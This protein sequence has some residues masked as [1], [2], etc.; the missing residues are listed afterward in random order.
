MTDQDEAG[1]VSPAENDTLH[2]EG[3]NLSPEDAIA[4]LAQTEGESSEGL[5]GYEDADQTPEENAPEEIAGL[6]LENLTEDGWQ[7]IADHLNSRGADRIAG[8]IKERSKLQAKLEDRSEQKEDPFERPS[9]PTKNPYH[10]VEPIDELQAKAADVDEMIEWAEDLLEDNEDETGDAIIHEENE[11]A[12]S[13]SE[14]RSLLR[15]ARKARKTHLVNRF[16][17]LQGKEQVS[18]QR[19]Q[20]RQ[21]AE[22]EFAWM[23]EED[24]PIRQRYEGV[25]SHPGLAALKDDF[26]EIPLVL[27][28]AADSIHRSELKRNGKAAQATATPQQTRMRPPANPSSS[29]AAPAKHKAAPAK[30]LQSLEAQYNETGDY[31]VLEEILALQSNN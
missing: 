24:S 23:K 11:K 16:Q 28:H 12:Y 26:P 7:Q 15:N 14:I 20:A 18:I 10:A 4:L 19:Q 1:I 25:M 17:E 6:N 31:H 21:I 3:D 2:T 27:A 29:A 5:E 30:A 8:L 13:K 22:E 9:D